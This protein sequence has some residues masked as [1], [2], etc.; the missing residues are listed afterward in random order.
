[1]AGGSQDG[2]DAR[3]DERLRAHHLDLHLLVELHDDR[4]AAVLALHLLLAPVAAHAT[5]GDPGDAGLAQRRLDLG[6]AFGPNDGCDEF[7]DE[8]VAP[9]TC[10]VN[11]IVHQMRGLHVT[12]TNYTHG[13]P[14]AVT[15]NMQ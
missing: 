14:H 12:P 7:H 8:N 1:G 15:E 2:F 13:I 11:R 10:A 4:G 3:F 5:E 6:Q 9:V